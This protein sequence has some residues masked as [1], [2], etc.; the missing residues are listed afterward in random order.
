MASHKDSRNFKE[1]CTEFNV[2]SKR[3]D[4]GE[5]IS[6]TRKRTNPYDHLYDLHNG[7]I[8]VHISRESSKKYTFAK[9]KLVSLGC[10]PI[11]DGDMEGNFSVTRT[12]LG[13]VAE[14]LACR[15]KKVNFTKEQRAAIRERLSL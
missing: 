14:Y 15:K 11:Q 6:P 7:K 5:P 9:K 8:G 3:N 2:R 13:K 10:K 4:A 1:I 12:H